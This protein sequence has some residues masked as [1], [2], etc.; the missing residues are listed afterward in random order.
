MA[1]KYMVTS[2]KITRKLHECIMQKVSEDGYGARGKSKWVVESVGAFLGLSYYLDLVDPCMAPLGEKDSICIRF[3]EGLVNQI[4]KAVIG[5][6][7]IS[8]EMEGV[9]SAIIRASIL[10]RFIR[11]LSADGKYL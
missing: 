11:G 7:K 8:P 6:R 3:P 9:R 10:Q 1:G 4:D 2:I 5:V